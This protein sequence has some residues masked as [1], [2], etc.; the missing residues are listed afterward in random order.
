MRKHL[1]HAVTL[2]LVA[3]MA[4]CGRLQLH[5]VARF[6]PGSQPVER[7]APESGAYKVKVA[8]ETGGDLKTVGGSKRMI[9]EGDPL[10]FRTDPDG[11]VYALAG[12]EAFPVEGPRRRAPV[13]FVWS[14]KTESESSAAFNGALASLA[15]AALYATGMILWGFLEA[16]IEGSI[17]DL[18]DD[19]CDEKDRRKERF[20][21]WV[22]PNKPQ[23]ARR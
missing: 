7:R 16:M 22:G 14:Y 11:H 1:R 10:G 4:G 5:T 20:Y 9:G 15:T 18:N 23:P 19:D 8:Y 2:S 3:S 21:Y 6:I 12:D 13:Y 17:D